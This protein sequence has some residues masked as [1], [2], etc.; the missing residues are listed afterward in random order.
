MNLFIKNMKGEACCNW[1]Q[2]VVREVGYQKYKVIGTGE[3]WID[4]EGQSNTL[5]SDLQSRLKEKNM[6]V[7]FN[8]KDILTEKVKHLIYNMMLNASIP[9]ENYSTFIA[10][11]LNLSY[12]YLANIFSSTEHCTIEQFIIAEKI[13]KAKELILSNNY[14]FSQISDYLHYS[15]IA[16]FSAQ[17]KKVTGKTA[18]SFK[19]EFE[20]Q[21]S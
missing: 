6:S 17:F 12:T 14:T 4:H 18:S 16:H 3:I 8:R 11:E 9:S 19:K 7:I 2:Q 21:I 20:K 10:K 15:S 13:S 1:L 5:L